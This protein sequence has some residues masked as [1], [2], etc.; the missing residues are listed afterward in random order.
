M[1]SAY[2]ARVL[3][4]EGE[5]EF[6]GRRMPALEA[7]AAAG[8]A[9]IRFAPKEALALMNGTTFMTAVAALLLDGRVPRAARAARRGRD[10][11]RSHCRRRTCRSNP[12]CTSEGP[13]RPD[14]RGRVS[15]AK[16]W[17][18]ADTHANPAGR[19]CYSLRC[20]PQ[21]LGQVW[22]ALEDAPR[23]DRARDQ[24]RQRQ[25]A[26]RSRYRRAVQG[27]QLLRRPHLA[28]AGHLEDRL[29][30]AWRTGATRSWR[31][32]VDDR[33]SARPARQ[34]DARARR[35]FRLQRDAVE[36]DQPVLRGAAD[37]RPRVPSTRCLPSSTTR[38][39][40]AWG[41]TPR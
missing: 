16:C 8:I 29:R 32:L 24:F 13:S 25:P 20:V 1:P 31:V 3:V 28:P 23:G 30:H 39:W 19:A 26:D 35:Q 14:R 10:G 12:G 40:S 27:R 21:G 41:C 2:I 38:T 11:R 34:P 22:E 15:C 5:A 4:G 18:A 33:F 36:R 9:P 17:R 7:L 6:A 37:G